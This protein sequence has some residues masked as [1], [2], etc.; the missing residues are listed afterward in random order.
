MSPG[1]GVNRLLMDIPDFGWQF[2]IK[3]VVRQDFTTALQKCLLKSRNCS[4]LSITAQ[5][6]EKPALIVKSNSS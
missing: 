3:T 5:N 1:N 4:L 2:V 6:G